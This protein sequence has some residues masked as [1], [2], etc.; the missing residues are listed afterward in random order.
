MS[1]ADSE[2]ITGTPV[3]LAPE[4][5][6]LLAAEIQ[7]Y[8]DSAELLM[9]VLDAAEPDPDLEDGGDD[10]PDAEGESSL[11]W[12]GDV[13]QTRALK[14]CRDGGEDTQ[15]LLRGS[16][17]SLLGPRHRGRMPLKRRAA[18]PIADMWRP[19]SLAAAESATI[20][21]SFYGETDSPRRRLQ[22]PF[23]PRGSSK[24]PMRENIFVIGPRVRSFRAARRR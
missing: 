15:L 14:T 12:T 24:P 13:N 19:L 21:V 6:E 1:R 9:A 20:T 11:G 8:I 17:R 18:A 5:R 2:F 22:L 4:E 7:A 3:D 16:D 23:W 10:E